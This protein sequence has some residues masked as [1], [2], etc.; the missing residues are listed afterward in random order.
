MMT[1]AARRV[2]NAPHS[3]YQRIDAGNSALLMDTG[4]PPPWP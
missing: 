3:G 1:R 4:K 2:S